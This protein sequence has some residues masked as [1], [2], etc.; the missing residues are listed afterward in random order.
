MMTLITTNLKTNVYIQSEAEFC[1]AKMNGFWERVG[2]WLTRQRLGLRSFS[3]VTASAAPL[4][5]RDLG[6]RDVP[7]AQLVGSVSRAQNFTRHFRPRQC[8][9]N[10]KER[11]RTIYT[12]AVTGQGFPPVSVFKVGQA[13]FVK[14]GHHRASVASYLGWETIQAEVIELLP[15][16]LAAPEGSLAWAAGGCVC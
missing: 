10:S 16:E 13:Y 7:L 8:D 5:S 3:E 9:H 15:H 14:D 6:L 11:W 1:Q 2:S 12:L 4:P